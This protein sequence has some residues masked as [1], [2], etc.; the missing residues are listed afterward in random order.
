M[1]DFS[2][3][4]LFN[5]DNATIQ[6]WVF[7]KS[8]TAAK[9]RAW[10]VRTD[11][12]IEQLFRSAIKNEIERITESSAY[13]PLAQTNESSCL[14]HALE[15]SVGAIA[16]LNKVDQPEA[17][18]ADAELKHLKG[19]AG[20]VVKFQ[21]GTDTVYAVRKTAPTWKPT[22]RKSFINA[23]FKNGEL[24][25]SPE[26]SFSFD[27]Y[28]DFYC[29]NETL[30]VTS[31]RSYESTVSD[32]KVY[33]TSFEQLTIDPQFASQFSSVEPLKQYVG[34]NAMQLR[35]ITV[36]QQKALY[37]RPDF[38]PKLKA[39]SAARQW[40]LNFDANDRLVVCDVTA[41]T[42]MQVLLDHRLLSEITDTIYDVPDAEA[43]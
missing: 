22:V 2:N 36:I 42:I 20:Y 4:R 32:K 1:S 37:L 17:E 21:D 8:S 31:K 15:E 9:F 7:K 24:S 6:L 19:A 11:Q 40:G 13:S 14:T 30:F 25:A 28:F 39:V 5:Y 3:W 35:R 23:F 38:C 18:N 10:H 34:T 29:F 26:E 16:L 27:S 33:E 43:V 41:R 12:Q